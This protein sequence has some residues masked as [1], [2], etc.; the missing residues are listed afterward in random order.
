LDRALKMWRAFALLLAISDAIVEA[1]VT[2]VTS[3]VLDD[4]DLR[5]VNKASF[6]CFAGC[7]VYSPTRN[8]K[9]VIVDSAGV[10][11]KSLLFLADQ[12]N[13]GLY[14]LPESSELYY[15]INDGVANPSFI[16]YAVEKGAMNYNTQVA[17]LT[18]AAEVIASPVIDTRLTIISTT[19]AVWFYNFL[20]DYTGALPTV[21]ATGFDSIYKCRPVYEARSSSSVLKTAFLID[22]PIA[23]ID[24]KQLGANKS[25]RISSNYLVTITPGEDSSAVYVSPG[26]VGC[27]STGDS[28]Y[29]FIPAVS[30]IDSSFSVADSNGLS[31][32]VNGEYSIEKEADA[33]TLTINENV[34]KLFG[35][36]KFS[37]TSDADSFKIG[38]SWKN[39]DYKSNNRFGLQIDV[40]NG[41]GG[42]VKTTTKSGRDE[43]TTSSRQSLM[44]FT[45]LI[46]CSMSSFLR[47]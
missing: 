40:M 33:I 25:V 7:R 30:V 9:I 19:G 4:I 35:T 36:Q 32:S 47:L 17:Y 42:T 20:G 12:Q 44:V 39:N 45:S 28:L 34:Q 5:G 13:G 27:D 26:Y 31:V 18:A 15:L 22:S 6:R 38:I 41:S 29:T 16:F 11:Y 1:R 24:F 2:F 43:S 10:E 3:E 46:A 21:H 23:T 14:E 8:D 37:Q